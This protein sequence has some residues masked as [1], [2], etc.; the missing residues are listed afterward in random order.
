MEPGCEPTHAGWLPLL[1]DVIWI[2]SSD[3]FLVSS[4]ELGPTTHPGNRQTGLG[5]IGL[6]TPGHS[7]S[8]PVV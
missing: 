1:S 5:G 3:S 7:S 8:C 4:V 6:H 2:P